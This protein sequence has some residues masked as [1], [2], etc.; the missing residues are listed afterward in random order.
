MSINDSSYL[1][2]RLYFFWD[3]NNKDGVS[4]YYY[5]RNKNGKIIDSVMVGNM[6][7]SYYK[8][9]VDNILFYSKDSVL[10]TG[11]NYSLD[12]NFASNEYNTIYLWSFSVNGNINW[13][14][15]Y[16]ASG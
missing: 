6:Q 14:R 5:H 3:N 2:P 10:A 8:S 9:S 11:M 7:K 12:S 16:F 15:Y 13:Q 4:S 1:H